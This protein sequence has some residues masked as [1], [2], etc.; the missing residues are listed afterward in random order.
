MA[1]DCVITPYVAQSIASKDTNR[2][3]G[4]IAKALAINSPFVAVLDGGV[5]PAGI[6]DTIRAVIQ[7]QALPGDSLVNPAFSA[8]KDLC[9]PGST[10]EGVATTE[11][12]YS[13]GTKRGRGRRSLSQDQGRARR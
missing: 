1:G 9:G 4:Q 8:T 10:V 6:S 5:L 7:E 13:L 11:Y 12:T 2:L 3:Q